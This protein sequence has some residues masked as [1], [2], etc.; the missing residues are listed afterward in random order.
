[1]HYSFKCQH[2]SPR[3]FRERATVFITLVESLRK[4]VSKILAAPIEDPAPQFN[5]TKALGESD[6]MLDSFLRLLDE[7]YQRPTAKL[8]AMQRL[9]QSAGY[10]PECTETLQLLCERLAADKAHADAFYDYHA[11]VDLVRRHFRAL[12][13]SE[14]H[15]TRGEN[16]VA[17]L[18][19]CVELLLFLDYAL[20]PRFG[21]KSFVPQHR[22]SMARATENLLSLGRT[23][24][25]SSL[26]FDESLTAI[27]GID[28]SF[29]MHITYQPTEQTLYVYSPILE[30]PFTTLDPDVQLLLYETLLAGMLLGGKMHGGASLDQELVLSHCMLSMHRSSSTELLD[31]ASAFIE[32]ITT[33]RKTCREI[34]TL[35][36]EILRRARTAL[37]GPVEWKQIREYLVNNGHLPAND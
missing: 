1:V 27:L 32:S 21:S 26:E 19:G 16:A 20:P 23:V 33:W 14:C 34:Q 11:F 22:I 7:R 10:G 13:A 30:E 5:G 12:L 29:S 17:S 37:P 36:P 28:N 2:R 9:C 4:W 31:A 25:I 15:M 35:D 3:F 8:G 6:R 18:P 24:G